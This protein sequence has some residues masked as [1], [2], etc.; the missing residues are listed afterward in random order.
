MPV[1]INSFNYNDPV[2]D[3][4]ILYMQKPYEERSRKYYKAFEIMPNVWIMP[5][6]DT[7]GTK[8]D[9][10]Q[11]PD[12]LK[13]GSSAYY[14]PNYLTTDAEKDRYLKTMIKLFN[15]INSNPTGKVL[16]ERSIKC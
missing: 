3:E 9:D 12:S 14:D 11:V 16:L 8:P 13:N 15:R 2:N 7:I 1:V 6:R 4:T 10:F 5:E